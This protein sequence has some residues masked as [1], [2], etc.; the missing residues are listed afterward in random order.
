V[1]RAKQII[2]V[3]RAPGG[4]ESGERKTGDLN[5]D[6]HGVLWRQQPKVWPYFATGE[7]RPQSQELS[8]QVSNND[9]RQPRTPADADGRRAARQGG[10]S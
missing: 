2:G 7:V 3:I 1:R 10:C 9:R 6:A 8:N 4:D 5:I